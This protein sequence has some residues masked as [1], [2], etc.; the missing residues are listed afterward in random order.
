[1]TGAMRGADAPGADGPA[2]LLAAARVAALAGGARARD[3]GRA[4]LRHPCRA[5]RAEVAHRAALGLRLAAGRAAR[6]RRRRPAALL[7]AAST[8][9][10]VLA[11]ADG[12]PAPVA[13][14]KVAMGDDGRLLAGLPEL[15]FAGVVRRGDGCGPCPRRHGA[16][17]WAS[18]R[19]RCRWCWRRARCRAGVHRHLRLSGWRDRPDRPRPGS[20]RLPVRPQ[21]PAAAG[22]VLA[23][24]GGAGTVAAGLR[25]LSMTPL[26]AHALCRVSVPM[27]STSPSSWP[28]SRPRS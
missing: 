7:R 3:A 8:R 19:P 18:S 22:L 25:A 10:P 20:R 2:N 14:V 28:C 1:M 21:G 5:L 26:G 12:P 4:Q 15:G 16:R 11:A 27:N 6:P 17:S 13:L 9:N 23:I 24:R